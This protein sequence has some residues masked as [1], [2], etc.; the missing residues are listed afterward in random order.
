MPCLV[1]CLALLT[2]RVALVLVAIFSHFLGRAY[3]SLLWP[4]LGF[5]FMPLTTL[6]YAAAINWNGQVTGG[7]FVMVLVAALID[8]GFFGGAGWHRRLVVRRRRPPRDDR[9]YDSRLE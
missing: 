2:P 5:F 8:L 6:A 4:V 9:I 7:Y 1:G 3:H